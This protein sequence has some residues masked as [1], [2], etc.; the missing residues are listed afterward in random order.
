MRGRSRFSVNRY[1]RDR[2]VALERRVKLLEGER[3]RLERLLGQALVIATA[4]TPATPIALL[5][6]LCELEG[7][8]PSRPA[9]LE[10]SEK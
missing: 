2:L 8:N 9:F 6:V 4:K 3:V 1:R 7:T 10:E 5:G